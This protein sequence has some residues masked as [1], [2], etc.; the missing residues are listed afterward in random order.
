MF[1]LSIAVGILIASKNIKN[2]NLEEILEKTVFIGELSLNGKIE[3]IKGILP[4]CI[5]AKKLGIKKIIVPQQNIRE[6]SILKGIEIL[7]VNTLKE[8]ILYLNGKK[9]IEKE[10]NANIKLNKK[11]EYEFDFSE[12]KGQESIKRALEIAAAGGHN[13]LLIRFARFRKNH[14]S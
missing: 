2:P 13:C 1:D 12:V 9:E 14:V 5:E 8:V 4:I 6:A 7:P 3:K 10:Q 11:S